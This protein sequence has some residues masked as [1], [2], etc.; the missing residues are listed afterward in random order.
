MKGSVR[1]EPLRHGQVTRAVPGDGGRPSLEDLFTNLSDREL[2]LLL[3]ALRAEQ[4][5][6]ERIRAEEGWHESR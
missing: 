1:N 6:R 2:N 3:D 4:A 5:R